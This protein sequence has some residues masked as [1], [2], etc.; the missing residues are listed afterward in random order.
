[1]PTAPSRLDVD[2]LV[3]RLIEHPLYA[4]VSDEASLRLFMATHVFCVWDFQSLLK[5]MQ[6]H[7][8]CVELPWRPTADPEARRLV[9]ELVLD[10]ESDAL[11]GGRLLSHFE[12][13]RLAMTQA[14]ADTRS[15]DALLAHLAL[16]DTL[17]SAL[18]AAA[19][20]LGAADFVTHTLATAQSGQVHA[21][22]AAFA[23][24]REEIIPAMFGRLVASLATQSPARWGLMRLY[25][26]RHI[27][28]DAGRHQD[29]SRA[30]VARLCGDDPRRWESAA[31]AARQALEA[32][33]RLWDCVLAAIESREGSA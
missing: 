15:I 26:E 30:I 22:A 6:R 10:E 23:W 32:R 5:A 14:G 2:D 33:L 11:P 13:Y 21:I 24:G 28:R 16:G 25:L 3:A 4:A 31:L 29:A 18:E 7:L 19:P 9:N 8:T 17:E 12:L 20:P 1:M 27:E